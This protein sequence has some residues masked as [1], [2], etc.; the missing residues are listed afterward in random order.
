[1]SRIEPLQRQD[2]AED[3]GRLE[4]MEMTMGFVPSSTYAMARVPGLFQGFQDVVKATM[5]NELIPAELKQLI[6]LATSASGGCRYCQAHTA[7]GAQHMGATDAKLQAVWEYE[8]SDLFSDAERAAIR[9]AFKGGQS[10]N[11]V[12]D[13]DFAQLKEH[14]NDDQ[15]AAIVAVIAMFGFLNRWND[16]AATTLEPGQQEFADKALGAVGWEIGKHA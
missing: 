4:F 9:V 6:G 10:P 11:Q 13:D 14:W 12:N 7:H 8:S 3:E 1:M 15:A 16:T 2:L 5:G